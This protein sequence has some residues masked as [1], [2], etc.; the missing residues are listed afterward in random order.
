MFRLVAGYEAFSRRWVSQLACR[1]SFILVVRQRTHSF[2]G[3]FAGI[4]IAKSFERYEG[5]V[6]STKPIHG[7]HILG[8][9]T[10]EPCDLE[11]HEQNH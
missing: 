11:K 2:R 4:N 9:R 7:N 6:L 5:T 8:N 10:I 1:R 3:C